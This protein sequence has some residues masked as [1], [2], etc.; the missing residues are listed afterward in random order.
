MFAISWLNIGKWLI[1]VTMPLVV[2]YHVF[3]FNIFLNTAV[4][5]A[6]GLEYCG[7]LALAPFQYLFAGSSVLFVDENGLARYE[8]KQRFE[9]TEYWAVK[10]VVSFV[11]LPIS[12]PL[13]SLLK[14]LSYLSPK[15]QMRH[16]SIKESILSTDIRSNLACYTSLGIDL[17]EGKQQ[18][19]FYDQGCERHP[20]DENVLLEEKKALKEIVSIFKEKGIIFWADCGTCLGIYRYGGVIPWD[21]DIDIGVFANDFNNV[22]HALNALDRT[23]YHVQDWSNRSLPET[24]IRVYIYATGQFIDIYHF[25]IYPE[26]KGIRF[27]LSNE[28]SIFQP[29][30]W[31][32]S[33]RR[34]KV[35]TPYEVM[36][37]L[38]VGNYD[39]IELFVPNDIER[40]LKD[41]YGENLSPTYLYNKETGTYEKDPSHPFW[42]IPG[43]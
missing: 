37:P 18:E 6:E 28:D 34:F 40:Y 31:K 3:C 2:L 27:I 42:Q 43:I 1:E 30:D 35:L 11:S 16:A 10:G 19:R 12:L 25:D 20:G 8:L 4:E 14:G 5:E 21:N 41:R 13:G 9:Y 17:G 38:K 32:I 33:N 39:G 36:F 23:K 26:E 22:R 29:E 24:L 15:V 7:N